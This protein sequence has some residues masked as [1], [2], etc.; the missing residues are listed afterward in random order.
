M[1]CAWLTEEYSLFRGPHHDA[2]QNGIAMD[3]DAFVQPFRPFRE[4]GILAQHA[5]HNPLMHF[6]STHTE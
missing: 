6:M 2:K 1:Q 5:F 3:A 4:Y